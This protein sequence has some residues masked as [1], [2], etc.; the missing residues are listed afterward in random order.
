MFTNL[1]KYEKIKQFVEACL[2]SSN[3]TNHRP[4][5]QN[6]PNRSARPRTSAQGRDGKFAE[7]QKPLW[8]FVIN[9]NLK[10]G[11]IELL[12]I[13]F[14]VIVIR[15]L[16]FHLKTHRSRWYFTIIYNATW[17]NNQDSVSLFGIIT[18]RQWFCGK[19]IFPIV[20]FCQSTVGLKHDDPC[21]HYPWCIGSHCAGTPPAGTTHPT[22]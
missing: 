9:T 11:C 6:C 2:E 21:D 13:C 22:A 18:A 17:D 20:C 7:Q 10:G 14:V 8:Y 4:T 5:E 16:I 15:S 1:C 12:P 19:V 3:K